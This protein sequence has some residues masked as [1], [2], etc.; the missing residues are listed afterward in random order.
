MMVQQRPAWRALSRNQAILMS[1]V[2]VAG[3]AARIAVSLRGHNYD[4]DSYRVVVDARK[5]GLSP[6][7]TNRYNY[8]PIWSYVL[9]SFDF[10]Q[11]TLSI[12]F[13]AQIISLLTV[14]DLVIAYFIWRFS[15]LGLACV[16]FLN[17]VSVIITGFHNQFDNVAIAMMCV[18]VMALVDKESD[19]FDERDLLAITMISLSL[20]TKH[21]FIFF[22]LW[23]ALRQARFVRKLV[24][25]VIPPVI[26]GASFLPYWGGSREAIL[27]NVVR[28]R[29]VN[30]MPLWRALGLEAGMGPLSPFLLFVG[31]L[32]ILGV[33][34]RRL[35]H[36]DQFY[37]YTVALIAFSSALGLQYT[38]IAAVGLVGLF[39]LP[40]LAAILYATGWLAMSYDG[41]YL[42]Q[43]R[44]WDPYR[45]EPIPLFMLAGCAVY[46]S[47]V[48]FRSR[49]PGPWW[50]R[51]LIGRSSREA[52]EGP[53]A[54]VR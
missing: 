49:G 35:R 18:A 24:Y 26:F 14:A 33:V 22:V 15:G 40:F 8:G 21:V 13:R 19:S 6:W 23:I 10:I 12:P 50:A 5:Q 39:N 36:A 28:Y 42:S 30:N 54:T 41:L 31:A 1:I 17:P 38:A 27:N 7:Q 16:F 45:L 4:F 47:T 43:L 11:R 29:S 32:G 9:Y 34:T 53:G 2:V 37:L 46:A 44:S 48:L 20:V 52:I 51:V 3:I 25:L